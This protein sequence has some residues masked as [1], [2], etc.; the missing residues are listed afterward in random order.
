MMGDR[1]VVLVTGANGFVGRHLVPV[2]VKGG[3]SVDARHASPLDMM[4]RL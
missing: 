4:A 2:L 3:W 1:P